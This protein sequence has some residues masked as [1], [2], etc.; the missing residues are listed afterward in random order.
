MTFV[1]GMT[2]LENYEI[3]KRVAETK[4]DSDVVAAE[5]SLKS[6]LSTRAGLLAAKATV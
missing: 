4:G 1:S 6:L 5:K 2:P 3:C